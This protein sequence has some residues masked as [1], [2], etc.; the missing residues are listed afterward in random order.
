MTMIDDAYDVYGTLEEL[1][2]FTEAVHRWDITYAM[3]KLPDYMKILFLAHHNTV[4]E[5]VYEALRDHGFNVMDCIKKYWGEYIESYMIEAR[6]HY[7]GY[8]P[9]QEEYIENGYISIGIPVAMLHVYFAVANPITKEALDCFQQQC[10]SL[11]RWSATLSRY[12]DDL[13]TFSREVEIG[14]LSNSVHFYMREK[15]ASEEEARKHIRFLMDGIWK[16]LNKNMIDCSPFCRSF[17][18]I[19]LN[20]TRMINRMYQHG[21]GHSSQKGDVEELITSILAEPIPLD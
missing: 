13:G 19:Q 18:E 11:I 1:E 12:A 15:G 5:L 4:N 17:M 3:E 16:K 2:L 6:R 10:P 21:D 14:D 8:T 7:G 9:T 20:L